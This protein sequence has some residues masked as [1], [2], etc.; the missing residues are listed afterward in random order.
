MYIYWFIKTIKNG[1]YC[2]KR[3]FGCQKTPKFRGQ[4]KETAGRRQE[5]TIKKDKR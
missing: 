2:L 3:A 4:A 5:R 1:S